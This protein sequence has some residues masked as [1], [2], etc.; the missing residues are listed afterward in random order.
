M[1]L[2][3]TNLLEQFFSI[4]NIDISDFNCNYAGLVAN[5]SISA[6]LLEAKRVLNVWNNG[7]ANDFQSV[8]MDGYR[9]IL[10]GDSKKRKDVSLFSEQQRLSIWNKYRDGNRKISE[11]FFCRMGDLFNPPAEKKMEKFEIKT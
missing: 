7:S 1:V 3:N 8:F 5:P 10:G 9:A 2:E 11:K 4:M 6:E